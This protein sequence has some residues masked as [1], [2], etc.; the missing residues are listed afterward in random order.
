MSSTEIK[1]AQVSEDGMVEVTK[2][3]GDLVVCNLSSL[4]LLKVHEE[5]DIARVLPVQTR[6]LDNVIDLNFY[7][8]QEAKVTNRKYRAIGIGTMIIMAC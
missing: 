7:P 1:G 6:M 3:P 5:E 2:E 8:V 4:N